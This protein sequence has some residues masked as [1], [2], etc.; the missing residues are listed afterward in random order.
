MATMRSHKICVVIPTYNNAGTLRQI[1]DGVLEYSSDVIVVNDGSTDSTHEILDGFASVICTVSLERNHGKG[2]A[3]K[4]GFRKARSLGYEYAITIDSD[5]QH[6]PKDI[7]SFVKAIVE[8]K[9]A[10][11]VGERDLTDVD[12]N[13]KSAFANKFSNFWFSVQTGRKLRDTQTGFRAYPLNSLYGL[14]LMTSRYEAELELLVFAAWNG[15]DILSIPINVYYPPRDQRVSHFR[16]GLDFTRIS[17][18]NTLLCFGAIV[19]GLPVRFWHCLRRRKF[20]NK[21]F[22]PFT[23]RKGAKLEENITVNRITR[24]VYALIQFVFWAFVVFKPYVLI[25][26]KLSKP[27]EARRRRLH[28][29]LMHVS[30]YFARNFPGGRV[31]YDNR[32]NEQFDKPAL[33]ISNHQSYLDL[34][35]LMSVSPKLIFLTNDWVWNNRY[36]GEIVKSAEFLPVSA[37]MDTILPSLRHLCEKGYSIVVFPEGT[38]SA[39]CSIG[40]FH[41]GAFLLARELNLDIVPVV[42]HGVGHYLARHDSLFRK[43]PQTIRILPRVEAHSYSDQ[44]LRKQASL[45]RKMISDEYGRMVAELETPEYWKPHVLNKYAYRGW[46]TVVRAKSELKTLERFTRLIS[47][48]EGPVYFI[49]AGVGAIPMLC[50]M[51]NK[52]IQI[53]SLVE[54]IKDYQTAVETPHQLTNLHIAH[55]IWNSDYEMI[56][57]NAHV[58]VTSNKDRNRFDDY[59]P[60]LIPVDNEE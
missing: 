6:F 42:L 36:F 32:A 44:L 1:L 57:H 11:I 5:G 4:A 27:T 54:D 7:P 52:N 51:A 14:G 15:V 39:D 56:P 46:S 43:N 20:L 16:P 22:K 21:E 23:R 48:I 59:K 37:G 17:I 19:Y 60:I 26:F 24:S 30:S 3:L 13:G 50:A 2:A 8:N 38:R 25:S 33:I 47:D 12:I 41:Q 31:R 55:P 28:R 40:R 9:G 29:M 53:Y 18:L 49:N 34:P 35:I 58:F 45:Y 10:L